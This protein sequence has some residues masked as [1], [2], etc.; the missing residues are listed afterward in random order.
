MAE[1][2]IAHTSP[3]PR[4]PA[5][6]LVEK[7]VFRYTRNPL[8]LSMFVVFFG[9][10]VFLNILWLVLLFPFLFVVMQ[11]GTVKPEETYLERTFGDVYSQYKKRVR[12]WI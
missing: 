3:N 6:A 2:R 5:T 10:A 1:M 11:Q 4:K 9:I 8:Y 12:R 7:G